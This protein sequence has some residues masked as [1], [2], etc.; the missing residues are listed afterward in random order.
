MGL[1]KKIASMVGAA[2][3][4]GS[5]VTTDA[6]ARDVSFSPASRSVPEGETRTIRAEVARLGGWQEV[7]H[8][9]QKARHERH[10]AR[11][12]RGL[13]TQIKKGEED[14]IMVSATSTAKEEHAASNMRK[15]PVDIVTIETAAGPVEC[16]TNVGMF[17]PSQQVVVSEI[18]IPEFDYPDDPDNLL[19][20]EEYQSRKVFTGRWFTIYRCSSEL[21]S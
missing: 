7:S 9:A 15:T 4:L 2:L 6:S 20:E 5:A 18:H 1:D 12:I 21:L 8:E 13:V 10:E 16:Q 19:S 11:R 3:T 14:V 17:F